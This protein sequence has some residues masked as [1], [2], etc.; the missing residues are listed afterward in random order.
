MRILI[1]NYEY[2]PLGGGAGN[3]TFYILKEFAKNP[4]LEIDLVTSSIGKHKIEKISPNIAV[5]YLNIGKS[6]DPHYQK[7]KDLIFYSIKSYSYS[8]KLVKKNKYDLIHAFFGI[9]CGFIAMLLGI[10]YIVSLRGSDVPGYNERFKL[11][12]KIF[13]K[14]ISRLVWRRARKITALSRDL[15]NLARNTDNDKKID[16]I[17]NGINTD[18]FYPDET[19]LNYEKN[20][21]I[22][23]VGRLI[24]RKGLIY[25][26]DAF[27]NL[28]KNHPDI[29]LIVAG[30]GP[31]MNCFKKYCNRKAVAD[32]VN[33]L[34][35]LGHKELNNIYQKTHIFVIPSLNE[36][37]GN[38]TLEA[39]AAGLPVISTKTGAAEL[40]SDN[41]III[42]KESSK[43][44]EQAIEKLIGNGNLR[45]EMGRKSRE[46]ALGMGWE[47]TASQYYDLYK[48]IKNEHQIKQN[49]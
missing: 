23:F 35:V 8:K 28:Q 24:K 47:K 11:F 31:L 3:A 22:L 34:G 45:R 27:A 4:D 10:P 6:G 38:V 12:D 18:E 26:L 42:E 46:V 29:R 14:L 2:P 19:P 20:F 44:I 25:L 1:L 36:A 48:Q 13:L 9:P 30:S 32:K 16:V 37:L 15:L 33:F 5:H 7:I 43:Q 17:Y 41:G 39:L 40:I 49:L 21:N